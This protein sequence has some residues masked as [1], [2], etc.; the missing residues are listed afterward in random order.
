MKRIY[1][2]ILLI[3]L[4]AGISFGAFSLLSSK[5]PVPRA[6]SLDSLSSYLSLTDD[7][8]K[9]LQ[10]VF[11]KLEY[12]R[13]QAIQARNE[14]LSHMVSV[15]RSDNPTDLQVKSALESVD[16]TQSRLR[17]LTVKHLMRLKTILT[18]E[19]REKLFDLIGQRLSGS[20]Y[21]AIERRNEGTDLK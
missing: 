12:E 15:L 3:I 5:E 18:E 9:Q 16:T 19:Q 17:M 8:L 6:C 10:P 1:P 2:Y 4:V 11:T 13:P 7:Q 20:D 14:A 21:Q